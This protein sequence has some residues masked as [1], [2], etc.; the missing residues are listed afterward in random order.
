MTK[1]NF[2]LEILSF[3]NLSIVN[4]VFSTLCIRIHKCELLKHGSKLASVINSI[5]SINNYELFIAL[6]IL[7]YEGTWQGTNNL[8]VCPR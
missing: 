6:M 4:Y 7:E 8:I 1:R 5:N 3:F 2:H